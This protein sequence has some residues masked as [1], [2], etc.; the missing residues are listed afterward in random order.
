L[1]VFLLPFYYFLGSKVAVSLEKEDEAV[2]KVD[3]IFE[4]IN[5]VILLRLFAIRLLKG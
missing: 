1:L 3:Y 5:S 4:F 2:D